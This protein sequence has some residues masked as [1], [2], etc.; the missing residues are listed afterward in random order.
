MKTKMKIPHC[1][2]LTL[3]SIVSILISESVCQKLTF[4]INNEQFNISY[5]T[6]CGLL[7]SSNVPNNVKCL[8]L[9][10]QTLCKSVVYDGSNNTC[11][12]DVSQPSLIKYAS[13]TNLNIVYNLGKHREFLLILL[14]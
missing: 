8:L 5:D 3:I 11:I 1:L 10:Q 4:N 12:L 7:L 13:L 9:C 14:I 6:T 2:G